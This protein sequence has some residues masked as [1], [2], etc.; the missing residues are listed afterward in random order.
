MQ[1]SDYVPLPL[2]YGM[3]S[4]SVAQ[5]MNQ[6]IEEDAAD[7]IF[8]S[9]N[10][11]ALPFWGKPPPYHAPGEDYLEVL[12]FDLGS[13]GPNYAQWVQKHI[14]ED[15]YRGGWF[16]SPNFKQY[17]KQW[18]EPPAPY[19]PRSYADDDAGAQW[20]PFQTGK[21]PCILARWILEGYNK[22]PRRPEAGVWQDVDGNIM[23]HR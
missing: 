12:P 8:Y 15:R 5:W 20:L 7:M 17:P 3:G 22:F 21:G 9:P 14:D 10:G 4:G 13:S 19:P 2:D 23:H 11:K 1:T 18:G 6:K 16:Y